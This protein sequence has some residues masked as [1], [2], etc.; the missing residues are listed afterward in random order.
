MTEI[1]V[2]KLSLDVV[3]LWMKRWL[4]LTAGTRDDCNMMTVAWGSVGC[5]W[6][7]PFAQ[8]VVR[9]QRHTRGYMDKMDSFTLCAFPEAHRK[10]LQTMGTTS[11]R[12]GDKLA[13]TGLTLTE[14]SKVPAP[15]YKEADLI[16]ECRTI[17]YQDMDPAGF[18]DASIQKNYPADDYH[19]IYYGE[20]VAAFAD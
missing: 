10:D 1:D 5:M 15:S 3:D 9:P 17:Y 4:L 13:L 20:I 18:V 16:L 12:D 11:G 14:S 19:R 7:K 8:V 2:K 6:A